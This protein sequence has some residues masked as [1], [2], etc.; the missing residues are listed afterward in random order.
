MSRPAAG[1]PLSLTGQT[2]ALSLQ[3]T[4]RPLNISMFQVGADTVCVLVSCHGVECSLVTS[5]SS[6]SLMLCS[7]RC[8]QPITPKLQ[9]LTSRAFQK[10]CMGN[11]RIVLKVSVFSKIFK[12]GWE[13]EGEGRRVELLYFVLTKIF[14]FSLILEPSKLPLCGLLSLTITMAIEL[15]SHCK[16]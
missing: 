4:L 16:D 9:C 15:S 8:T 11:A 6:P 10:L 3:L 7:L 12:V 13:A 14:N 1:T 2:A 5:V